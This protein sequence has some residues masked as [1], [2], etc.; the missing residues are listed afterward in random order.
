[1]L[2]SDVNVDFLPIILLREL[3]SR[4]LSD[5]YLKVLSQRDIGKAFDSLLKQITELILDAPEAPTI[6]GEQY[7]HMNNL[8]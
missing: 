2:I 8:F 7:F 4:L 6:I 1:M 3:T 5:L